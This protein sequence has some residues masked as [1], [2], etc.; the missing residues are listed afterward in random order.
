MVV[1]H[2]QRSSH[3]IHLSPRSGAILHSVLWLG[4]LYSNYFGAR[5]TISMELLTQPRGACFAGNASSRALYSGR[6][7]SVAL[8]PTAVEEQS[9]RSRRGAGATA[10]RRGTP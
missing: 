3:C 8:L 7:A 4:S 10:V 5:H 6:P 9:E 1:S 2:A